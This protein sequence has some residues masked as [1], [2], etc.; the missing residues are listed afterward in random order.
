MC[1]RIFLV[2][3]ALF[4]SPNTFWAPS[5]LLGPVFPVSRPSLF[6]PT[7]PLFQLFLIFLYALFLK[8]DVQIRIY[9]SADEAVR[10]LHWCLG[11]FG[12]YLPPW[13]C[14]A[15]IRQRTQAAVKTVQGETIPFQLSAV[16]ISILKKLISIFNINIIL[17]K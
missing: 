8:D 1:S 15:V 10:K 3:I 12:V 11:D 4:Y 7:P 2:R 14:T 9:C 13:L 5:P 6:A 17:L 16:L